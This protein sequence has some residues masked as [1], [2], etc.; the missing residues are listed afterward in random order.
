[1]LEKIRFLDFEAS[2]LLFGSYPIE[3]G[4]VGDGL[5]WSSLIRC[6][7]WLDELHLWDPVSEDVHGISRANIMEFG[8]SPRLVAEELMDI[9]GGCYVFSDARFYDQRWL[10]MLL[11]E[12]GVEEPWPILLNADELFRAAIQSGAGIDTVYAHAE[13]VVPV[14]HRAEADAAHLYEAW[15]EC[16][17][18]AGEGGGILAL[19][20]VTGNQASR[21]S[22]RM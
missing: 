1:M 21:P 16:L 14:R 9:V 7:E 2:G 20:A 5:S 11:H 4:I 22:P 3:A 15:A 17:R 12:A 8:L 18:I 13:S 6:D 10:D 19:K